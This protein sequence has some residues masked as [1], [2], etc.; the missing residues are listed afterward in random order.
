MWKRIS[1]TSVLAA[2]SEFD[3]CRGVVVIPRIVAQP[4]V[5][6]QTNPLDQQVPEIGILEVALSIGV[7]SRLTQLFAQ[8]MVLL[9]P[10]P[11]HGEIIEDIQVGD[12]EPVSPDVRR[13]MH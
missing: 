3:E 11:E 4:F 7:Q 1:V 5:I 10:S 2:P 12:V 9:E 6:L 13:K 8:D